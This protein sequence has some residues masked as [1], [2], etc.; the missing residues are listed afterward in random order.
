[1]GWVKTDTHAGHS[2]HQTQF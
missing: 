2:M 1:M